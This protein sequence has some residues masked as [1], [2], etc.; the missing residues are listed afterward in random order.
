MDEPKPKAMLKYANG[1]I[2]SKRQSPTLEGGFAWSFAKSPASEK[3][4]NAAAQVFEEHGYE[5]VDWDDEIEANSGH[6][7]FNLERE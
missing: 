5:I 2:M 4:L 7:T 1:H 6:M 3:G